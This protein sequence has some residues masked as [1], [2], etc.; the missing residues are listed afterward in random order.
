MLRVV[1][2]WPRVAVSVSRGG[3]AAVTVTCSVAVPG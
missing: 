3:G 1:T 2:T